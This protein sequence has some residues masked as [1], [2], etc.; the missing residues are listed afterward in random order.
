MSVDTNEI[1]S[2]VRKFTGIDQLIP[3][4]LSKFGD[5]HSAYVLGDYAR[6]TDSG[7]NDL[8]LVGEADKA[9]LQNLIDKVE[10]MLHRKIRC[11]SLSPQ[12]C[13]KYSFDTQDRDRGFGSCRNDRNWRR[14][15][16]EGNRGLLDHEHAAL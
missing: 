14:Q 8:V 1:H 11:L 2:M 10:P 3:L 9:Y 13:A 7:I 6:G 16:V 15:C 12:Y 5:I 4:V